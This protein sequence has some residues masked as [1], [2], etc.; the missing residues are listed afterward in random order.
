M[1]ECIKLN[2][3]E[4]ISCLFQDSQIYLH[5]KNGNIIKEYNIG[6]FNTGFDQIYSIAL[7]KN[8]NLWVVE[9]SDHY[10]GEFSLDTEKELFR[11]GGNFEKPEIFNYPEQARSFEDFMY[12]A[13]M[14]NKRICKIN[15]NTK[16][17][18]EYLSFEEPVWDYLQF[19]G[20]EIVKLG[21]GLYEI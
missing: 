1:L 16:E 10:V 14:G 6:H 18:T 2:N 15:I 4:Y 17:I 20:K 21:S 5:D 11:V 8:N 12:I 19:Q 13:D 7:D 3:G 9:P